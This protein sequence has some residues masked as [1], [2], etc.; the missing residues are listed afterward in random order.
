MSRSLKHYASPYYDPVKAHE[1][2]EKNKELKGRRSTSKLNDEGKEIWSYTKDQIKE[3]KKADI[4]AETDKKNS[5]I[6]QHR[7]E[8]KATRE[9]ISQRLKDLAVYLK[10]MS[11]KG[12][13]VEERERVTSEKQAMREEARTSAAA[14]REQ[15]ASDLKA[16]CEA[17]RQAYKQAKEDIDASYEEIYQQ[18]FDK[19]AEEYANTGKSGKKQID[20]RARKA[21]EERGLM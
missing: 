19:I 4:Q 18:E 11:T 1:Y 21:Y 7:A 15:V 2:Y 5:T 8:A 9:R 13:S 17:T 3:Q 10:S 6:E 12:L 16:V 20:E 14:E